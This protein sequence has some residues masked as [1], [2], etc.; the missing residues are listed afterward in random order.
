M[1]TAHGRRSRCLRENVAVFIGLIKD[2]ENAVVNESFVVAVRTLIS[3]LQ[4][5]LLGCV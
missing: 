2:F 5:I 3:S 1:R 4:N